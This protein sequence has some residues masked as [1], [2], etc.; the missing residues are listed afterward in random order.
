MGNEE[1]AMTGMRWLAAGALVGALAV[2]GCGGDDE[3]KGTAAKTGGEGAISGS[4]TTWI[5][6]PGSPKLQE[7]FNS[8][9]KDFEAEHAGSDVKIEFVPWAQA[10]DKFTTAIAGGK[11][12]DVAEMG[13]TWTPEFADQ[14]AFEPV[15]AAAAGDYVSSLVDAAT[16]DGEVWGKPWYAG[17]RALIYRKDVLKKAGVEPPKTWDELKAAATAIK[18]KGGGIYPVAFNGLTEHY[19][20]PAIWQAGGEI[21]TQ[22]GE[23][24]KA[25]LN[26]P[27]GAEAIDF[28]TSFYKEGLTPKASIGWEEPDAQEAFINGDVAMLIAGGWTYNSIIQTKPE[29]EKK[30]GTALAPA[31]PSGKDTAFAGGS[32]LVVFKESKDIDTANAFVDFML[33]PENLN[34]FTSEIG[35]LPGTT[36]G[37]EASGYLE[38]PVRKPFAEQLLDHS[39]VYPPSPR[40]GALEGANIFDGVIQ[41]VMKGKESPQEAAKSLAE[42]MDQ[43]FAG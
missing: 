21:A 7:V 14:G 2:A 6:D 35:F 31:G 36:A 37:I 40:W 38:D 20:L 39:A 15:P 43:E 29:L 33:E 1:V 3:D 16:L 30:I 18:Q 27:E 22:D 32:H 11:V 10:H 23:T 41:N 9:A 28:Y 24:W 25:A 5:M 4:I 26:S 12:P 13:T 17:A 8:Y 19:Y 34:K 42:Q